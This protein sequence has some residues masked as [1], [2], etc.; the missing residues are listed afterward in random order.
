MNITT[1]N[2]IGAEHAALIAAQKGTRGAKRAALQQQI[3]AKHAE[4]R[5]AQRAYLAE[6][7][8]ARPVTFETALAEINE[9]F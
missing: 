9:L 4:L 8:A 1:L 6:R 7:R 5:G 2:T 3:D